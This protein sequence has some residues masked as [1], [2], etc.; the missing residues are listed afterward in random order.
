[1][2]KAV[3]YPQLWWAFNLAEQNHLYYKL[4]ETTRSISVKLFI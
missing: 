1:M 3:S 4:E 2:F